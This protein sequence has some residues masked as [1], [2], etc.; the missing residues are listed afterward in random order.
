MEVYSG[1]VGLHKCCV[2]DKGDTF[3]GGNEA[4]PKAAKETQGMKVAQ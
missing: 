1:C 3:D 4:S 2:E